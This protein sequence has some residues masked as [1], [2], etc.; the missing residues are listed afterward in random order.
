MREWNQLVVSIPKEDDK[1]K[2]E[3]EALA[4][5]DNRSLSNFTYTILYNYLQSRR[6]RKGKK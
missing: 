2:K 6:K 1:T 4:K 5:K 3:L